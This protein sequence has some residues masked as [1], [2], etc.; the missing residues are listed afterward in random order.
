MSFDVAELGIKINADGAIQSIGE[1]GLKLEATAAKAN[2]FTVSAEQSA[3][4]WAK[5]D[6]VVS[7]FNFIINHAKAAWEAENRAAERATATMAGASGA[8][9]GVS[10]AM[11]LQEIQA[12]KTADAMEK[13]SVN[14]LA[15][16]GR[17]RQGLTSVIAQATG[18]IPVLD[19]VGVQLLAMGA[20][21]DIALAAIAGLAAIAYGYQ[22]LTKEARESAKEQE[23]FLKSLRDEIKKTQDA[24]GDLTLAAAQANRDAAVVALAIA[25]QNEVSGAG[26]KAGDSGLL[27]DKTKQAAKALAEA[28]ELL[29]VAQQRKTE[30]DTKTRAESEKDYADNL[31]ML[32]KADQATSDERSRALALYKSNA[33]EIVALAKSQTDNVRRAMLIGENSTLGS[34]LFPK[35]SAE[36][37]AA[38][39]QLLKDLADAQKLQ[40]QFNASQAEAA[41]KRAM[42]VGSLYSER[43]ASAA[44]LAATMAGADALA[45]YTREQ[46]IAAIV[47]KEGLQIGDR[48]YDEAVRYATQIVDNALAT[49]LWNDG[50]KEQHAQAAQAIKDL[51]A[52][53]D[54]MVKASDASAAAAK[55]YQDDI[56]KIWTHGIEQITTHGLSSFTSFF[57]QTLQLFEQLIARMVKEGKDSGLGFNLLGIGAGAISGGLTG[58]QLGQQSG[59]AATGALGG[60]AAGAFAG[61]AA[62]PVGIAVGALAGLAGGILG[63]G[64]AADVAAK[65]MAVLQQ[66]LA[67]SIADVK[68]QLANDPLG[69]SIAQVQAQFDALRKQTEDAYAG[70]SASSAQVASRNAVLSQL[71]ALEAQR[72]AQ[73]K[74]EYDLTQARAQED[75]AVRTLAAQGSIVEAN[76]LAFAEKQQREYADALK[77]G[78]DATTLAALATTQ[79]AEAQQHAAQIAQVEARAQ[80]DAQLRLEKARGDANADAD[81]RAAQERREIE[82]LVAQGASSATIALTKLAQAAEDAATASAA[83]AV[84]TQAAWQHTQDVI[85]QGT[86]WIAQQAAV[87]GTN[88]ADVLNQEASNFGFSGMTPEQLKAMYT[89]FS[90]GVELTPEQKALN[91]H[92]AKY[93][94]DVSQLTPAS[95]AVAAAVSSGG[96]G[97]GGT[98]STSALTAVQST[99]TE[100]TAYELVD[101]NRQQLSTQ[102]AMLA[103][104]RSLNRH[105]GGGSLADRIDEAFGLKS[106]A[107]DIF[108]GSVA[109]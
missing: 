80:E 17:I 38:M 16:F 61:S 65:Q 89:A 31:A 18:T 88:P 26:G 73:L 85:D 42:A 77:A 29:L 107:Q 14:Q 49:K 71:N 10:R 19:R 84:A 100:R 90:V 3:A 91:D 25:K 62:G 28:N 9:E 55:K 103:E 37:K 43:D 101:V 33:A 82:D 35:E 30:I 44:L 8:V 64:H 12:Y 39:R 70:G 23:A 22:Y 108:T 32:I 99:V 57:D 7:D 66:S 59:S 36:D 63:A 15:G 102:R 92:I 21:G 75:S 95:A 11:A 104:L 51:Q 78:A 50:L 105:I 74:A 34:A 56:G 24:M 6:G 5:A 40:D 109:R 41:E 81:A 72:I 47:R 58:Y 52:V 94:N 106:T 69:S 83:A 20:G 79:A 97:S 60:A 68:A 45:A 76:A 1:L 48:E 96:A 2:V 53:S 27:A 86:N 98:G 54:A 87:L 93:L 67:T 13:A 4:A 46:A